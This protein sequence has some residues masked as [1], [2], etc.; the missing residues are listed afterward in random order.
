MPF[1]RD[2][3]T[4]PRNHYV[5]A[6]AFDFRAA[7]DALRSLASEIEGRSLLAD[8]DIV[9]VGT[10][11]S[12][13]HAALDRIAVG[14]D[15]TRPALLTRAACNSHMG[16]LEEQAAAAAAEQAAVEETH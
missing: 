4:G 3:K 8:Q 2:L 13:A 11:I 7:G 5:D 6:L 15:H 14:L 12:G 10:H 9:E 16:R 1:P